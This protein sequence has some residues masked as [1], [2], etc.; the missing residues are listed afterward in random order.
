MKY[1]PA[2]KHE[3]LQERWIYCFQMLYLHGL[4]SETEADKVK[5]RIAKK[6][7]K[8]EQSNA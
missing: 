5:R 2:R 7:Q 4:I 6:A 1:V 3:P 8:E